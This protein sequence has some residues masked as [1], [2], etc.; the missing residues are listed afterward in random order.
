L[1]LLI[2]PHIRGQ[3]PCPDFELL[4]ARAQQFESDCSGKIPEMPWNTFDLG[5]E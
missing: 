3:I 1:N 2:K 5:A 4:A